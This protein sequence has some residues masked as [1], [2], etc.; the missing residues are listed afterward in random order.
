MIPGLDG[1]GRDPDGR[2]RYFI[3]DDARFGSMAEQVVIDPRRSLVLP[4][5]ADV[6]TVAAAMNPAMSSWIALRKRIAFEPGQSVLVLGATGSAG[7]MAVQ[8]AKHLG[9][10]NVVAAGRHPERLALLTDLGADVT[11]SLAGDPKAVDR[12]LGDAAADI[13]VVIDYSGAPPPNATCRLCSGT[14]PTRAGR[15]CGSRSVRCRAC[16]SPSH[17]PGYAPSDW[18][19]W[20][21]AK[22][23]SACRTTSANSLTWPPKSQPATTPSTPSPHR[24]A[25]SRRPGR[26]RWHLV[27]ASSSSLSDTGEVADG[28]VALFTG[29]TGS[30]AS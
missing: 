28:P 8:M 7:Q 4:T 16:R 19:L 29:L 9:A 14:A 3:L 18:K 25:R 13:D 10:G 2:L 23:R 30:I 6:L 24:S 5:G 11:I 15:W 1:V 26:R 22:D 20:A 27:N 17:R 12:S 21:A